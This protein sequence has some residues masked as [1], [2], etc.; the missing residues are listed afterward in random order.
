MEKRRGEIPKQ[1]PEEK[2]GGKGVQGK[3][4]SSGI[5]E[6]LC[7]KKAAKKLKGRQCKKYLRGVKKIEFRKEGGGQ[8][9]KGAEPRE[10]QLKQIKTHLNMWKKNKGKEEKGKEE[11][12]VF[13][14]KTL[15]GGPGI[16]EVLLKNTSEEEPM[17]DG[18]QGKRL[19]ESEK[20]M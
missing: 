1:I 2:G 7:H 17:K 4:R 8:R 13:E 10:P 11:K 5:R 3:W 19:E 16:C 20:K 15:G 6:V 9:K 12:G 18:H 14:K